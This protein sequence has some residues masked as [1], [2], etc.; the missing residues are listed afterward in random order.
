LQRFTE[1][2]GH[3]DVDWVLWRESA[4]PLPVI[5]NQSMCAW[6]EALA[7]EVGRPIV[8]GNLAHEP[9]AWYNGIFV[10]LP[11]QGLMQPYYV[12]RK[13]VPFG[14]YVPFRSWFPGLDKVVPIGDDFL[15]G[16]EAE[17]LKV[18]LG[19]QVL[20]CGGLV[21]YEDIF[22][23]LAREVS[24]KGAQCLVVVTNDAWYGEEAGAYQHAAHS[25]L[26]AVETRRPVIRSGNG[27]WSG[28]IDGMGSIREVL[29]KS[30]KGVYF[31]GAESLVFHYPM[32]ADLKQSFYVQWGDW[33]VLLSGV[34]SLFLLCIRQLGT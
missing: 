4:T 22:P 7:T 29:I 27:G 5:G 24:R 8:M 21:C 31:R 9:E 33:F 13:L 6:V 3:S 26:R 20:I 18:P 30:G 1:A 17:L 23:Q 32:D 14:E 11:Y 19:E 28:W 15:P 34:F 2:L 25:V 16:G 10:V 12:K